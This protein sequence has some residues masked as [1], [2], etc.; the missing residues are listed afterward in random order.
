MEDVNKMSQTLPSCE[1]RTA[2][3]ICTEVKRLLDRDS[4][5]DCTKGEDVEFAP[6]EQ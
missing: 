2:V 4:W 1:D 5:E 6:D 3:W